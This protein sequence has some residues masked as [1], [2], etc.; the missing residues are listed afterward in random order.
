MFKK[1]LIKIGITDNWILKEA[2]KA[3]KKAKKSSKRTED[4]LNKLY[5]L[6]ENPESFIRHKIYKKA[7]RLLMR[8]KLIKESIN[9]KKKPVPYKIWGSDI[10]DGALNQMNNACMLP[11]AFKGALMPDAH[12]GYGL[13]IGGVLATKNAI[14]PYAVGMGIACRMKLSVLDIGL[15][16]FKN[17]KDRFRL[18]INK[19]TRFGV[20]SEYQKKRNRK[21]HKVMDMDWKF[22]KFIKYRK[23]KAWKQLGTSGSENHFAEFG[24]LIVKNVI[25]GKG[26][27]ESLNSASHGAGRLMSRKAAKKR[28]C[29]EDIHTIL[30]QKEIELISAGL[31]EIP[32]AYKDIQNVMDAQKDLVE[33]MATYYPKLVKMAP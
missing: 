31:D 20:G 17:H 8:Q 4:I 33:V 30:K 13:P 6:K 19:V 23:D 18:A 15:D 5:R 11:V 21:K 27:V 32:L 9:L 3:A 28:F 12:L 22:C 10:E 26:N 14:I 2:I 25:R 7:A 29:R 16:F 1:E 24:N